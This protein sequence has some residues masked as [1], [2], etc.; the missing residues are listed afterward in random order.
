MELRTKKTKPP[1]RWVIPPQPL[2]PIIRQV[3]SLGK[4]SVYRQN[5][6]LL[7]GGAL[8]ANRVLSVFLLPGEEVKWI[9]PS[10][11]DGA[12]YVSGYEIIK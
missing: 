4:T 6:Y 12:Q 10:S 1:P 8:P 2:V 11:F 9:G 7:F 5:P 3:P